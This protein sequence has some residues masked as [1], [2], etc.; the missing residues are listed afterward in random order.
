MPDQLLDSRVRAA[1][2]V[3]LSEKME[4]VGDTLLYVTICLHHIFSPENI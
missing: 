1:F 4:G 3:Y 2:A